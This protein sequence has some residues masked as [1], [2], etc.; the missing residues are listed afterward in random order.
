M[1]RLPTI[2]AI[3]LIQVTIYLGVRNI[4]KSM[5]WFM[6]GWLINLLPFMG[7]GR[8]MF[9]YHYFS[10]LVFAVLML[11]YWVGRWPKSHAI[12][13]ALGILA[14]GAYG[15]FLPLTYGTSSDRPMFWLSAWR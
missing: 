6:L 8:V 1:A 4:E 3:S 12:A 7:I 13:F 5:G 10:A 9:L 14:L 2:A 11:A 15:Y